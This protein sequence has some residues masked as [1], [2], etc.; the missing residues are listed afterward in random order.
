MAQEQQPVEKKRKLVGYAN[1][2]RNNPKSDRFEMK[3]FHHKTYRRKIS[4]LKFF[5]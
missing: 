5:Y 1:F 2:K 3:K 4:F